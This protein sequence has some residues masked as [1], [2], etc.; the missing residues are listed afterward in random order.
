MKNNRF[1]Y[2]CCVILGAIVLLAGP[3]GTASAESHIAL[4]GGQT[5][6]V[7]IYSHIYSGLKGRPFSLAATLSIR[8]T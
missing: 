5:V 1:F 3:A 4:S 6:Y 2:Y 7:P 8:N